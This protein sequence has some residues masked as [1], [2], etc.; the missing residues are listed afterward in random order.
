M[1]ESIRHD[2]HLHP[3]HT[4]PG[5]QDESAS[6][7]SNWMYGNRYHHAVSDTIYLASKHNFGRTE[8]HIAE[9][10]AREADAMEFRHTRFARQHAA[11]QLADDMQETYEEARGRTHM[12]KWAAG[13]GPLG[14]APPSTA[15]AQVKDPHSSLLR[16]AHPLGLSLT[17]NEAP[18]NWTVMQRTHSSPTVGVWTF[19]QPHER[20]STSLMLEASLRFQTPDPRRCSRPPPDKI[21]SKQ[22]SNLHSMPFW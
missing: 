13:S 3:I 22:R 20:P 6:L 19:K 7:N 17:S 11:A 8:R 16:T 15:P 14:L 21:L 2:G 4:K 1:N 5:F 12:P 18:D 10:A 9:R